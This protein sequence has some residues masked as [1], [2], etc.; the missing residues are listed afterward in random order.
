LQKIGPVECLGWDYGD[1]VPSI[2]GCDLVYMVDLC[3]DAL[4]LPENQQRLVWIDHHKTSIAKHGDGWQG[5]RRDGVAACRL[6]W[7]YLVSPQA[8]WS[9][10][11]DLFQ[12][13]Q[14]DEPYLV[15]LAGEYDVWDRSDANAD[16]LQYAVRAYP[17]FDWHA[18]FEAYLAGS[19][20]RRDLARTERHLLYQGESAMRY[21]LEVNRIIATTR[22]HELYWRGLNWLVLN[23]AM[24]NSIT[25]DAAVKPDHDALLMWRWDGRRCR[26]SLYGVPHRKDLDLS[27][28][29]VAHGGG[30]HRQACGFECT[31]QEMQ[32]ILQIPAGGAR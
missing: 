27:E 10:D 20:R 13:R 22:S 31:W 26:V 25:F 6:C 29:A 18:Y 16:V 2:E 12:R 28:I 23:Q 15:R 14:V 17:F 8:P 4:L 24:G 30:G 9:F 11:V 1:P 7:Q 21:A 5:V 3:I 19:E 32:E